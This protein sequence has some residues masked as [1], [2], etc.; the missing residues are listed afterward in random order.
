M[1]T[2]LP[3]LLALLPNLALAAHGD[4]GSSGGGE[5]L[6]DQYNPWFVKGV[7]EVRYCLV[8]DTEGF[9]ASAAK[10][11][12]IA[13]R[14]LAYW[15]GE[16]APRATE[17]GV[18]TQRFTLTNPGLASACKGDEDLTIKLGYG[19]LSADDRKTF[20]DNGEDPQDYVGIAMRTAY[21]KERL[22]ARGYVF[23]ASDRG[24][25][26]YNHGVGVDGGLWSYDGLLFRI[27]QHELGHVFGVT[28]TEAGFMAADFPENMMRNYRP[29]FRIDTTPFFE[30]GASFDSCAGD[31][32]LRFASENRWSSFTI[33]R[34][35]SVLGLVPVG[36]VAT[37]TRSDTRLT[38]P[39]KIFLPKEQRVFSAPLGTLVLKGPARQ[40]FKLTG[41]LEL[42]EGTRSPVLL[43]LRPDGGEAY[44]DDGKGFKHH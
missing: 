17:L 28:H 31:A 1:K 19:A 40:Q 30:P 13:A 16:L 24:P 42:T 18:G 8:L 27:L 44:Y 32:C 23:I 38:F 4:W 34:L 25:Y 3:A 37:T 15:Q 43:E 41:T 33:A 29:F 39:L 6:R 2:L 36:K 22:R 5:F 11:E 10:A 12:E 7:E 14:A 9:S 26:L 20:T 35:D 21:D